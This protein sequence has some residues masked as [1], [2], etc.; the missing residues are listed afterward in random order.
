MGYVNDNGIATLSAEG[1]KAASWLLIADAASETNP[2]KMA[3]VYLNLG[4]VRNNINLNKK[5]ENLGKEVILYG[6]VGAAKD[7][8][9]AVNNVSYAEIDG[10][11][12]GTKPE[13]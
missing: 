7:N 8:F 13:K 9:K 3:A 6:K 1:A 4:Q 5:P 10:S 11:A 12:Y 2:S